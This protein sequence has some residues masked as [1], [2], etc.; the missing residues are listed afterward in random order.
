MLKKRSISLKG[1][2]TSVALEPEF[3]A[4]LETMASTREMTLPALVEELDAAR[5]RRPRAS[6]CRVASLT[7]LR[8]RGREY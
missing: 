7:W 8:A 3:W 2:A 4:V 5:A 1:H 6:M